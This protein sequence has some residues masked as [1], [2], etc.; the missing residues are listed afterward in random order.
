MM[1]TLLA[2]VFL[3]AVIS[4]ANPVFRRQSDDNSKTIS[5]VSSATPSPSE[6]TE[7]NAGGFCNTVFNTGASKNTGFPDTTWN[8]LTANGVSGFGI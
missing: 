3:F 6:D 7:I 4:L 8:S 2:T 5:P 1:H